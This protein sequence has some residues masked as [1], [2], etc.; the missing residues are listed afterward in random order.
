MDYP[1]L[2]SFIAR[3][4]PAYSLFAP[5]LYP[6]AFGKG[7]NF[8]KKFRDP[9]PDYLSGLRETH[10]APGFVNKIPQTRLN[11]PSV[12]IATVS[13]TLGISTSRHDRRH[14]KIGGPHGNHL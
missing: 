12:I 13:I 4:L 3:V 7:T 8:L 9:V 1:A 5:F 6:E 2:D 14:L 10:G 11:D